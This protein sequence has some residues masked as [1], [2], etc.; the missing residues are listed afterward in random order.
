MSDQDTSSNLFVLMTRNVEGTSYENR[1]INMAFEKAHLLLFAIVPPQ[2]GSIIELEARYM[3]DRIAY[4]KGKI[5]LY[6][7]LFF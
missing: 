7:T 3:I 2:I 6:V 5:V 1:E 4:S